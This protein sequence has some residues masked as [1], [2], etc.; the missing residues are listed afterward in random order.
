LEFGPIGVIH[1]ESRGAVCSE[2]W[3]L[4]RLNENI[5][6]GLDGDHHGF[7]FLAFWGKSGNSI[8]STKIFRCLPDP[9]LGCFA[10]DA[11]LFGFLF[12]S[13]FFSRV[14]TDGFEPTAEF[15]CSPTGPSL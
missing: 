2:G 1:E 15:L 5:D 9:G 6:L 8:D 11:S 14:E 3:G 10:G 13:R 4:R 12:P 7:Y